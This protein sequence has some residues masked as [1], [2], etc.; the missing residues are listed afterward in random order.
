MLPKQ[1]HQVSKSACERLLEGEGESVFNVLF[2]Q[3][4]RGFAPVTAVEN[5]DVFDRYYCCCFYNCYCSC[6]SCFCCFLVT[7]ASVTAACAAVF[8]C[9]ELHQCC[10]CVSVVVPLLMR[11]CWMLHC[12]W[13]LARFFSVK[14]FSPLIVA[15]PLFVEL[16]FCMC[17][18]SSTT[19]GCVTG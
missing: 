18:A 7:T 16:N 10:C 13:A 14:T 15:L 5:D 8:L 6:C 1:I 4:S 9:C 17:T 2:R 11:V 12:P 19:T 3:T